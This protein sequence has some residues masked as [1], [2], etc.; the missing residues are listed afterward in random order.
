M[1]LFNGKME[2]NLWQLEDNSVDSVVTDPP[3]GIDFMGKKWDYDVPSEE[4]WKEVLRVLK[5]GG[6][7]ISFSSARTYHRMTVAIED[8]G[9]EI[10]DQLMWVY[11]S[12][13]PKSHN[14]GK[15]YDKKRGVEPEKL[16]DPEG[17]KLVEGT[18]YR[19]PDG[20]LFT[21]VPDINGTIE[22]GA[23]NGRQSAR[24]VFVEQTTFSNLLEGWGT[25][26]KPSHEPM[27]LARKPLSE[28]T[29]LANAEK[30]GVGGLNID[31]SRV[32]DEGRWPA[33]FIHDGIQEDWARY[34][35]VPKVG[36]KER[37][38]GL[39]GKIEETRKAAGDF[40][41]SYDQD[42][43]NGTAYGRWGSALNTHPTVKP[44][45]LMTY[46]IRLTTPMGGTVLDPFMGSGST[47]CAAA[48]NGFDFVG[49]EMEEHSFEVA[50][51]RIDY[52]RKKG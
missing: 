40:R 36:K 17:M 8:A 52:W 21:K 51:A 10:R 50:K 16:F 34:F 31:A 43:S 24:R 44:I 37:N 15:A 39:D 4:Q 28:K 46:L 25:A 45:A 49:I 7:L 35:Y 3:Y 9:F 23:Q 48:H 18:N 30:W 6:H 12:G 5:P 41:P 11:G 26:L 22:V 47:G 32:G 2:D 29:V 38:E 42:G 13:F 33:N 27:V 19:H 14:L 1:E 20:R